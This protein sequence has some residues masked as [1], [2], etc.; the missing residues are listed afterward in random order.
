MSSRRRGSDGMPK[1]LIIG[2][3]L[4]L[5]VVSFVAGTFVGFR[6]SF[7]E[8]ASCKEISCDELGIPAERCEVCSGEGVLVRMMG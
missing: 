3:I 6:T 5:V 1:V 8:L 7:Q 4:L 2:A